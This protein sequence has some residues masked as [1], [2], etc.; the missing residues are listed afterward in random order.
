MV[1]TWP[2]RTLPRSDTTSDLC[3]E[4]KISFQFK[5]RKKENYFTVKVGAVDQYFH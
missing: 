1:V 3:W 5:I 4:R 2:Q